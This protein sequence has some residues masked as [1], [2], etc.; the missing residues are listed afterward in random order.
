MLGSTC[1]HQRAQLTPLA[2]AKCCSVSYMPF[3]SLK[4]RLSNQIGNPQCCKPKTKTLSLLILLFSILLPGFHSCAAQHHQIRWLRAHG[5]TYHRTT[6]WFCEEGYL[7]DH[8]IQFLCHGQ[9]HVSPGQVAQ[10]PVQPGL[11]LFQ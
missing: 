3:L 10:N 4:F 7:R 1:D 6:V 8:P 11:E 2:V 9:G 5:T